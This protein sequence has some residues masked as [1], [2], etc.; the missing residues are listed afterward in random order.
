MTVNT[1]AYTRYEARGIREDL[2]DRIYN[3]A[4]T[5]TPVM[6]AIE[7]GRKPK[8]T[9]FEWQTDTLA[10][11]AVNAA[12]DGAD[13]AFSTTTPTAR[14]CNYTQIF[15]K[16]VIVTGTMQEM[17]TAG[18]RDELLYQ[19]EKRTKEI[20]RDIEAAITGNAASDD[21]SRAT[22]RRCGGLE[23]WYR[24]NTSR[25]TG[26]TSG[27]FTTSTNQTVAPTD[28]SSTNIRTFT[29]TRAK[30]VIKAI[31]DN[32]GGTSPLVVVGSWVKQQASAF[33]G[34]ATRNQQFSMGPT[35]SKSLAVIGAAD[36]YVS[37]FGKHKVVA[38]RFSRARTAHFVDPEMLSLHYLRPFQVFKLAKVGDSER[39]QLL[40]ELT[41]CVKNEQAIGVCADLRTS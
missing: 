16:S 2:T 35:S 25:G 20:K 18:R 31:W 29:E 15:T 34:I 33:S 4:P 21:G 14:P 30:A 37:D 23:T 8:N 3:V 12:L 22:A 38:N 7:R 13:A 40:A 17:D 9:R 32:G 39:R 19:V 10:A 26:G 5:D 1:A 41:L 24:T 6:T 36:I 27:G 28:A 11:A